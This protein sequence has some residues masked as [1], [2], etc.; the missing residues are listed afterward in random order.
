MHLPPLL[1]K[2]AEPAM[3]AVSRPWSRRGLGCTT[4]KESAIS[5]S[6][7]LLPLLLDG[8]RRQQNDDSVSS[9]VSRAIDIGEKIGDVL[10]GKNLCL[11]SM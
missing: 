5:L 8:F 7:A 1:I 2:L 11:P 4:D 6:V 9:W 10:L 3:G